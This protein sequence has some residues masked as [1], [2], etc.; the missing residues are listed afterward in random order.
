L[1]VHVLLTNRFGPDDLGTMKLRN[2]ICAVIDTIRATSTIAAMLGCGGESVVIAAD[3]KQ[4]F[5]LKAIFKEHLLCGEVGGLAPKGFDCGNSPVEISNLGT[6]GKNFILMTTNG[7]QSIFKVS[8]CAEVF[9]LSILNIN[10]VLDCMIKSALEKSCDILLL[11]SGEKGKIAYDD[12]FTAGLAVKYLLTRP[13]VFEFSDSA[14]IVLG[15]SLSENTINDALEKSTSARSL[16][17][18]SPVSSGEDIAYVGCPN[19]F[20]V[21]PVVSKERIKLLPALKTCLK[22]SE[23]NVTP[24]TGITR[25][26]INRSITQETLFNCASDIKKTPALKT[27]VFVLRDKK[28]SG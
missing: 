26:Q 10:H 4:A 13:F 16:R 28:A 19:M 23:Q 2:C 8:E 18:V 27:F 11:C 21:A 17:A 9:T 7:T 14:K 6:K 3:K 20:K 1:K 22:D 15:T 25:D 5:E 24:A 12:A